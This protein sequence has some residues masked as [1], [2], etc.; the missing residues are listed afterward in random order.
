MKGLLTLRFALSFFL[1]NFETVFSV[2]MHDGAFS[3]GWPWAGVSLGPTTPY[4]FGALKAANP[5]TAISGVAAHIAG[6]LRLSF[7]PF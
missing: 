3:K 7:T 5:E 2:Y 1:N 6:G 4:T